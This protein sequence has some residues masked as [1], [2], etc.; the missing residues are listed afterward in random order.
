[1]CKAKTWKALILTNMDLVHQLNSTQRGMRSITILCHRGVDAEA[2]NT[3]HEVGSHLLVHDLGHVD[4]KLVEGHAQQDVD[5]VGLRTV[6]IHCLDVMCPES[7][8]IK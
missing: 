3:Q 2:I 4:Y 7:C 8:N 6:V 5:R 1:M